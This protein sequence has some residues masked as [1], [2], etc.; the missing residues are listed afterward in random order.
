MSPVRIGGLASG[1]DTEGMIKKLMSA[2]RMPLD[3]LK[4]KKQKEEWKRDSYREMNTLLLDLRT[5]LNDLRFSTAF[6]KQKLVSSDESKVSVTLNGTANLSSY[7]VSDVTLAKAGNGASVKF[8]N[9][10]QDATTTLA[11]AGLAADFSMTLSD[12][13]L[14]KTI[15][16]STTDTINTLIQKVNAESANTGVKATYSATDKS[17]VFSSTTAGAPIS[18]T[19]VVGAN[20]LN[21]KNGTITGTQATPGQNDFATDGDANTEGFYANPKTNGSVKING[22]TY[23]LTSNILT[24]DNIT[25][26]FKAEGFATPVTVNAVKDTDAIFDTIKGFV[27]KYNEVIDKLNQKIAEPVERDYQPLTDEE[28]SKLT[29]D[30]IEQ[31]EEKAK[32]GSLRSDTILRKTI[33]VM[34]QAFYSTISGVDPTIDLMSEIGIG[35]KKSDGNKYNYMEKGKIHIDEQK[36]RESIEQKGDI[37]TSLFTKSGATFDEKGL[38][39][40]LYEQLNAAMDEI[41]KKAGS[42]TTL[43]YNSYEMGINLKRYDDQIQK[44]EDKLIK[45]EDNYWKQFAAMEKAM[46]QLNSQGAWLAQQFSAQ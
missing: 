36:L 40:R 33:D 39:T 21:I 46:E 43:S 32:S 27:D 16:V 11:D 34:R 17:I 45:I 10:V 7:T 26:N 25:F 31:W 12:G 37:V 20:P 23:A 35:P 9:T 41:K 29:E 5:K 24:V 1:L 30:Q 38:S 6:N 13:T 19:G 2:E 42:S 18:I 14:S 15:T 28:R 8:I 22:V 3:K 4:Q 44:W